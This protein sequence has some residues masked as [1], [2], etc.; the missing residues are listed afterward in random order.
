M[1]NSIDFLTSHPVILGIAVVISLMIVLSF[2]R[3]II[4]FLI[5]LAAM[6]ILYIAWESWHGGDP[7]DRANKASQSVQQ[8]VHKSEGVIRTI[9][10]FFRHDDRPEEVGKKSK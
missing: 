5:V 10:G 3:K 7:K 9:D 4:H 6:A 1:T 2:A 8:A